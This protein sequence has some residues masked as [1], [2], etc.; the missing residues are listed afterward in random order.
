MLEMSQQKLNAAL[1]VENHTLSRT[2]KGIQKKVLEALLIALPYGNF[3][4]HL[5]EKFR[6][7]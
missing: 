2:F 5:R 1:V 4:H 3:S 6:I 7:H